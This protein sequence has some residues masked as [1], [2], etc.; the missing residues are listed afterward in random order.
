MVDGYRVLKTRRPRSQRVHADDGKEASRNFRQGADVNPAAGA[1]QELR[2]LMSEPIP[3][4]PVRLLHLECDGSP[5]VRGALGAMRSTERALACPD[6]PLLRQQVSLVG[7]GERAAMA[8][9]LIRHAP[10]LSHAG[11][12]RPRPEG[13]WAPNPAADA[14]L[15]DET[16]FSRKKS[17]CAI[18]MADRSF[19]IG[20]QGATAP[21]RPL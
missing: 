5:R 4:K 11:S 20:S 17:P 2:D 21:S 18:S 8:A 13:Q 6:R 14:P 7:V 3:P 16:S 10:T 15:P 9:T 12:A 19:A 1:D